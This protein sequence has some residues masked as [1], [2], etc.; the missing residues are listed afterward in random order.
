MTG[1]FGTT[2]GPWYADT[3]KGDYEV[4]IVG[5]PSWGATRFGVKGEWNVCKVE[6][7]TP[8]TAA[9]VRAIAQVPAMLE[10]VRAVLLEAAT[11][12]Q[13]NMARAIVAKLEGR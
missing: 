11:D 12:E 2:P 10:L 8:D 7:D 3:E 4:E 5:H 1:L 6:P 13:A 9:N